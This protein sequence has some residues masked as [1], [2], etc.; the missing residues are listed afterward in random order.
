MGDILKLGGVLAI[1]SLVAGAALA[2]VNI[3]TEPIIKQNRIASEEA[4]RLQVLPGMEGG[5]EL[6][7]ES[8]D[9]PYWVG[10]TNTTQSEVGGYVFIAQGPGYSSTIQTM[11]GVNSGGKIVGM[12]VLFQKETP[13]LGVKITEIRHGEDQPWFQ[14]QFIGLEIGSGKIE[15]AKDGGPID[16]ITGATISSRAVTSSVREGLRRLAEK[17]GMGS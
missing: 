13:G 4:A 2:Y 12:Q 1:Y 15:L 9:L 10:Y 7:D 3:R 5:F 17:T 16:A 6:K 8:S 14:R 11:V